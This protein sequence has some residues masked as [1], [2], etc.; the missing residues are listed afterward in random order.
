MSNQGKTTV[1]VLFG[2]RSTEHE[3]SIITGLQVLEAFDST[4]YDT[5]P[6]YV[7]RE[8]QW[9]TGEALRKRDNYLPREELKSQL[10]H[11]SLSPGQESELIEMNPPKGLFSRKNPLHFPVDVF[12]PAFHGTYGEDGCIQGLLELKG[13]AYTGCGP[14][15]SAIA[16]NKHTTK[17]IA[18]VLDVPVLPGVLLSQREWDPDKADKTVK[19]ITKKLSLPV[20]IKPCNLGSSVGLSSAR[21]E[22]QLMVSL[23]GAFAFDNQ[24]IVEPFLEHMYELNIAVLDGTP[25]RL[26]VIERPKRDAPLLTFEQKYMKGNKKLTSST[27]SEGMASLQRDIDPADVPKAIKDDVQ[28]YAQQTYKA[29]DCRGVI[30][31]DFLV[32]QKEEMVYLNEIN[33]LP[34]SFSYYLWE[35]TEP[36][37]TFTELLDELVQQAVTDRNLNKRVQ[38]QMGLRIFKE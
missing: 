16:M 30:R 21:T 26:S 25:P 27:P 22:E 12:F 8:G 18:S 29:L 20:I 37:L 31:I 23:A 1:A 19:E 34:G 9:Y 24:V 28:E 17:Q 35:K 5:F 4:R 14:R 3:I 6:V 11:V 33:P 7:D 13:V 32:D 10:T 2:G 15:A 36:K 38:R